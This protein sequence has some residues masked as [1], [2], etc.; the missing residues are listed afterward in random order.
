MTELLAPTPPMGWNSWNCFRCDITEDAIRAV[1]D[2][3][4]EIGLRDAGYRY[5]NLDDGW[6]AQERDEDGNLQADPARFPAGIEALAE[7]VHRRGLQL[8]I[9]A[10]AGSKTCAGYPGSQ[11]NFARDIGTFAAWGIDYLKVDWCYTPREASPQT[12]YGEI[13]AVLRT[14]RRPIILSICCW[15][16]DKPWLWGA[17]IGQLWRTSGDIR[18]TW[19]TIMNI[20]E[21]QVPLTSYA[22]PGGWNDPDMLEVGNGALTLDERRAHFSL[23]SVL[24]APLI[25]GNNLRAT[26]RDD[27]DILLNREVIAIDQDPLG[28]AGH[29]IRST[30]DHD[31]WTRPLANG[32][33][34]VVLLNRGITSALLATEPGALGL[35]PAPRYVVRDLWN[36]TISTVCGRI[37][38]VVPPHGVAMFR[39]GHGDARDAPPHV[40]LSLQP[41]I[42][43]PGVRQHLTA[44]LA[45][46]APVPPGDI[47]FALRLPRGWSATPLADPAPVGEYAVQ[48]AWAVTPPRSARG[49]YDLTVEVMSHGLGQSISQ[50]LTVVVPAGISQGDTFV[51]DLPW[52]QARN[53]AWSGW[54]PPVERDRSASTSPLS[55]N[56][57]RYVKG[58]GVHA[59]SEVWYYLAG[60][61]QTFRAEV[62]I[63]DGGDSAN[64]FGS[65]DL[66]AR[67]ATFEVWVDGGRLYESGLM[68]ADSAPRHVLV[69]VEGAQ[70]LVL[71]TTDGG[72]GTYQDHADWGNARVIS[73]PG[74]G[75]EGYRRGCR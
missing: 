36:G 18:P 64:D 43:A 19:D 69:D 39:V 67:T 2:A 66:A 11:G 47:D 51:S 12:V 59:F 49:P 42:L 15:G 16:V 29:R 30:P 68:T 28:V 40:T 34:A 74:I 37:A 9:Y 21:Q 65:T 33:C 38:A 1:A 57:T 48:A 46:D 17:G 22:G 20:V 27:R 14:I 63:D 73:G 45:V 5:I 35:A 8:G 7:Y 71:R 6:M 53:G 52:L 61:Y 23:W 72:D 32:D 70:I 58:L 41:S 31:V 44:T 4:V 54:Y 60:A 55:I 13:A 24:A 10:D 62:G 56:G 3:A 75:D 25:A 26:S 50:R